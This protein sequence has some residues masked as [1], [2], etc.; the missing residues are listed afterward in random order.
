MQSS[1]GQ[2]TQGVY[3]VHCTIYQV[4]PNTVG[5]SVG[6]S[7]TANRL[8]TVH[9]TWGSKEEPKEDPKKEPKEKPTEE[10]LREVPKKIRKRKEGTE[11]KPKK[12]QKRMES[13]H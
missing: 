10:G 5:T 11:K 6:T 8:T 4:M 9:I 2:Y 3:P 1:V 13:I 12:Y 7:N